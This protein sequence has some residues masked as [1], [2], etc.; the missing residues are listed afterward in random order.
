MGPSFFMITCHLRSL[1]CLYQPIQAGSS[2]SKCDQVFGRKSDVDDSDRPYCVSSVSAL[3]HFDGVLAQSSDTFRGVV[4]PTQ[5]VRWWHIWTARKEIQRTVNKTSAP[6]HHARQR[7]AVFECTLDQSHESGLSWSFPR[8]VNLRERRSREPQR[9]WKCYIR[10][11]SLL[12]IIL[13]T[14]PFLLRNFWNSNQ[15]SHDLR[16]GDLGDSLTKTHTPSLICG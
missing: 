12:N 4:S 10:V 8:Y 2:E 9:C 7:S 15:N 16:M 14:S 5:P 1:S 3:L 13:G 6:A 11:A